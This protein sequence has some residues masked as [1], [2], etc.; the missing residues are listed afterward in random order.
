MCQRCDEVA[1]DT[2]WNW[3]E[4]FVLRRNCADD[5]LRLKSVRWC[6]VH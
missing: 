1:A 5:R 4:S 2:L 6:N 3:A